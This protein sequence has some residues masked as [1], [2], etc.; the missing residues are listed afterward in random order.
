MRSVNIADIQ[1]KR[2]HTTLT[3]EQTLRARNV[4]RRIGRF[5]FPETDETAWIDDFCCDLI[6]DQE[7]WI[8]ELMADV[9]DQVKN[10][11]LAKSLAKSYADRKIMDAA[12]GIL[13]GT[14][15]IASHVGVS[16]D[17]VDLVRRVAAERSGD[18]R[19]PLVIAIHEGVGADQVT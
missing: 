4:W 1:T 13:T 17:F 12:V 2:Y 14:T 15:D 16:D 11:L 3:D 8:W 18:Q 7:L 10:N 19:P 5:V 9:S 6:P